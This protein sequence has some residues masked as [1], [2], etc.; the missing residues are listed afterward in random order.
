VIGPMADASGDGI[1]NLLGYMHG[2]DPT[3]PAGSTVPSF[4]VDPLG[5]LEITTIRR[6]NDSTLL[7][8]GAEVSNELLPASWRSS[9]VDVQAGTTLPMGGG[10]EQGTFTS[11][12][13]AGTV[14]TEFMRTR[15]V[16]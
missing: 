11:Q 8:I 15:V 12:T 10:F 1:V 5:R 2:L 16:P 4:G 13:T 3:M 7:S 9:P 6:I 14:N